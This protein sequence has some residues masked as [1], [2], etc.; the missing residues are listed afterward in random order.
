MPF[1]FLLAAHLRAQAPDGSA[2][3][4]EA[5]VALGG[6]LQVQAEAGDQGDARFSHD[7]DRLYL[8]RARLNA[9]GTL[10]EQF[11]FRLEADFAGGLGGSS[12]LRG[13]LTDAYVDWKGV[14]GKGTARV[15]VGQFKTPFGHEQLFADPR[16]VTIERSLANDRLTL[17]RQLGAQVHGELV[18]ERLTYALGAFNGNGANSNFNDDDRFLLAA[19]LG[20]VPWHARLGGEEASLSV[21]VDG[22]TS[23]DHGVE[24]AADFG[25]EDGVFA[26]ERRG[27]GLDGQLEVG[28]FTVAAEYL[29]AE[30]E[31]DSGRP[32]RRLESQGWY[33]LAAWFL[34]P[35]RLQVVLKAESFDPRRD[36]DDDE[37]LTG[38]AGVNWLL[39]GHD[40][41]LMLNYQRADRAAAEEDKLLARLQVAF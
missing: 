3:A 19:R 22:Y 6:L 13:Q 21:A 39:D 9:G 37:T 33:V 29:A 5:P 2:G 15:R 16:L 12:D 18:P 8:R 31:P 34:V 32:R 35:R 26:G 36:Q 38:V 11:D 40:L 41:K 7:H 28:R 4:G 23:T 30:W 17:G 27:L 25:F 1:V 14:G 20:G 24:V 10:L